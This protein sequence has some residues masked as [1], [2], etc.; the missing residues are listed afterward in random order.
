MGKTYH[1]F[2]DDKQNGPYSLR[3]LREMWRTGIITAQTY[4]IEDGATEWVFLSTMEHL[5]DEF[6]SLSKPPTHRTEISQADIR[7]SYPLPG[8]AKV[9]NGCVIH[10]TTRIE[11]ATPPISAIKRRATTA[12][13]AGCGS[14]CRDRTAPTS[15]RC[16]TGH[17]RAA[18]RAFPRYR[19]GRASRKPA[20]SR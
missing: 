1:I 11:S 8:S 15:S 19:S 20:P 13:R 16:R 2:T 10:R 17:A 14:R 3:Q 9:R 5:F 18:G 4:I 6:P 12:R 7:S